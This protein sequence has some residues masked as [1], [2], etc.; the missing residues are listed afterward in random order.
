MPRLIL[1]V[2]DVYVFAS[3]Y[4]HGYRGTSIEISRKYGDRLAGIELR[5]SI[6]KANVLGLA[7]SYV[8]TH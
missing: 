2:T 4:V 7:L 5:A 1:I 8:S 6:A 3:T